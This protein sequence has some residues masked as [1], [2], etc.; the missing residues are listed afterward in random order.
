MCGYSKGLWD[1]NEDIKL[2]LLS[3][4]SSLN[5]KSLSFSPISGIERRLSLAAGKVDLVQWWGPPG[6]QE[7]GVHLVIVYRSP[8][9]QFCF[10][11]TG[12]LLWV[13]DQ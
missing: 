1:L 6:A 8:P 3:L 2:L 11:T 4:Y 9:P 10:V 13:S 5:K 12:H 7:G